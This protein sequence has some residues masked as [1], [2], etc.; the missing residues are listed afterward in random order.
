M[1]KYKVSLSYDGYPFGGWQVQPNCPSIQGHLQEAFKLLIGEPVQVIGSGRTDAG[2]HAKNQVAHFQTQQELPDSFLDELNEALPPEI[3]LISLE[4]ADKDFHARFS[5]VQKTYHYHISTAPVLSPFEC[6]YRT[7][8]YYEMDFKKLQ[9]A[10]KYFIGTHDFSSFANERGSPC[11]PIKTLHNLNY[12]PE[13]DGKFRLEFTGDGFLYKMVRNLVG[14]L[15]YVARGK[16]SLDELSQL[17]SAKNRR[18]APP[19]APPQGLF[20]M[21]VEYHSEKTS[22]HLH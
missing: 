1:F 12:V 5:A 4:K 9:K 14:T 6:R 19:P 13:G 16:I 8:L 17:I 2:V 18:L 3:R 15:V 22:K 11:S 10:L 20:L 21:S 7:H